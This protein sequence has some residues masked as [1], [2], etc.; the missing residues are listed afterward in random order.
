MRKVRRATLQEI[1]KDYTAM[2]KANGKDTRDQAAT[3]LTE[4]VEILGDIGAKN[5][6]SQDVEKLKARLLATPARGRESNRSPASVNRYL[7]DLRVAYNLARRNGR[8]DGTPSRMCGCFWRTTSACGETAADEEKAILTALDPV[9]RRGRTDLRP[10]RTSAGGN[11]P[12]PRRN[13]GHAVAGR[14]LDERL[15]DPVRNQGR[16]EAECSPEH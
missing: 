15:C 3:R 2:L 14:G 9:R 11:W 16:R 4:V 1:A 13:L 12:T 8:V 7:Q 6:T 5:L 10:F